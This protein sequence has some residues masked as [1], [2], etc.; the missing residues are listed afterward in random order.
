MVV[1]DAKI[2]GVSVQ[3][4]V[5]LVASGRRYCRFHRGWHLVSAF[6]ED[7]NRTDGLKTFCRRAARAMAKSRPR[8]IRAKYYREYRAKLKRA[9]QQSASLKTS[10]N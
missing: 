4:F 8:R 1:R 6:A 3:Q 5:D 10:V 7:I 2:A 9:A